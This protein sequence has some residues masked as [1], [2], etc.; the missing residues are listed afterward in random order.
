MKQRE[1]ARWAFQFDTFDPPSLKMTITHSLRHLLAPKLYSSTITTQR[2]ALR[3]LN[4]KKLARGYAGGELDRL[5]N[6]TLSPKTPLRA[7][8]DCMPLLLQPNPTS[9]SL[10]HFQQALSTPPSPNVANQGH[11]IWGKVLSNLGK[12]KSHLPLNPVKVS[13]DEAWR[14]RSSKLQT[15][16]SMG[17]AGLDG[18]KEEELPT[19]STGTASPRSIEELRL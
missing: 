3:H 13:P 4:N 6:R 2:I 12:A 8:K 10:L 5:L 9:C 19:V 7:Q 11:M 16:L 18:R 17:K 1:A 15:D 14:L